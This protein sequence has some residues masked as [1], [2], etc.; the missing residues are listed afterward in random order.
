[1]MHENLDFICQIL[2]FWFERAMIQLERDKYGILPIDR[3]LETEG[4][5]L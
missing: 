4:G 1:M 5:N 3:L 2:P